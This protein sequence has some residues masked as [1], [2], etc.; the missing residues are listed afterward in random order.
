MRPNRIT[1]RPSER[2][3]LKDVAA[4]ARGKNTQ[5]ETLEIIVPDD[6]VPA[7]GLRC[8]DNALRDLGIG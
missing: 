8:I 5:A 6:I 7:S 2:T 4:S 1:A 3:I